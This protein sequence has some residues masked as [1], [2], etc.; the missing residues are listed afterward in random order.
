MT[1]LFI[2]PPGYYNHTLLT[3]TQKIAESFFYYFE[4]PVS[5]SFLI[6]WPGF[7]GPMV[8]ALTEFH[9]TANFWCISGLV[10]SLP[11]ILDRTMHVQYPDTGKSWIC[12]CLVI[13][14]INFSINFN[15]FQAWHF[16]YVGS[17]PED[18]RFHRSSII[19]DVADLTKTRNCRYIPLHLGWFVTNNVSQLTEETGAFLFS[20]CI[21]DFSNV[22]RSL[23]TMIPKLQICAVRD[24]R[25]QGWLFLLGPNPPVCPL[26]HFDL[27]EKKARA[28]Q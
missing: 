2:R 28:K 16:S 10:S 20:R 22:K 14:F 24:V 9:Y 21:P 13:P 17:I 11:E 15:S 26:C 3:Q 27:W 19:T 23:L 25:G 8:V 18:R 12:E 1:T 4:D 5:A 7:Y 6:L